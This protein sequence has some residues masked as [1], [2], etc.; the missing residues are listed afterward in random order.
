MDNE[1]KKLAELEFSNDQL[2]SEISCL[3]QLMRLVG[4]SDGLATV[5]VAA[6]EIAEGGGVE[7]LD[8]EA[9]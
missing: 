1:L 8:S 9:A 2:A 5:K 6:R 3:D 7:H 4:F